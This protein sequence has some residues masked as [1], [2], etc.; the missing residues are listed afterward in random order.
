MYLWTSSNVSLGG[1]F[2][3][4][5]SME[6]ILRLV[7]F[8][9]LNSLF[10]RMFASL[11]VKQVACRLLFSHQ[12][13]KLKALKCVFSG[14]IFVCISVVELLYMCTCLHR[15]WPI[16]VST[17]LLSL[18]LCKTFAYIVQD[19]FQCLLSDFWKQSS[20]NKVQPEAAESLGKK[21]QI[22][23]SVCNNKK[24]N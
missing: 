18:V 9:F 13:L 10:C 23:T 3:N 11:I 20:E 5:I 8:N 1:H 6:K 14:L 16:N 17:Q 24:Q 12:T 21:F 19:L 7:R 2:E 15:I 22:H 4:Y